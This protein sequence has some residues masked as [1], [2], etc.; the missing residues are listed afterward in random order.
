VPPT[1]SE[2]RVF[3]GLSTGH[4]N[5]NPSRATDDVHTDPFDLREGSSLE[6]APDL[7]S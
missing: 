6:F 4:V 5:R 1:I 3:A 7:C 2:E